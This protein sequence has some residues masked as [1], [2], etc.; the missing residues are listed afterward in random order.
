MATKFEPVTL[1]RIEQ[2]HFLAAAEEAF[3]EVSRQLIEHIEQH[4]KPAVAELKLAI[5][6][7]GKNGSYTITTDIAKALP[8]IPSVI[9]TA[10]AEEDES[11]NRCLF[12]QAGGTHKGDPRQGVLCKD[13]GEVVFNR[14]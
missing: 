9:T 7:A 1:H 3:A 14:T 2:G 10:M 8:R 4:D 6:I 13:T 11:G 5:K 12:S